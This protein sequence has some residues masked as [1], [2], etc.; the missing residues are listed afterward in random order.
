MS[1]P[2]FTRTDLTG[3][4]F[5]RVPLRQAR[6]RAVDFTGSVMRAV[7][8][9]EVD[10]DGDI[11]GLRINGVDIAP[12]V[13]AE[14]RRRQPARAFWN[15]TDPKDLRTAWTALQRTWSRL[16]QRVADMP[17]GT[18]QTSVGDEWSF[19]QTLRHLLFVTDVWFTVPS[20]RSAQFHPWGLGFA[21]MTQYVPA[22]TDFGLG[23]GAMRSYRQVLDARAERV[24]L[25]S[26]F[27]ADVS[28]DQ[29]ATQVDGPH[30]AD[31]EQISVLHGLQ[32]VIEE[33]CEHQRFAER[34]L[35]L[36]EAG[37]SPTPVPGKD[38]WS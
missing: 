3:A 12:L 2:E 22:G 21:G 11:V 34:D 30:W 13:E 18:S 38:S 24:A 35:D 29:L 32:V 23:D 27:L 37:A 19:S 10:I 36:I 31:T 15:A 28:P 33:E 14:L 5:D 17:T 9:E 6:F 1:T 7:S 4:R 25:V 16:Y 26:A 8:L 20:H